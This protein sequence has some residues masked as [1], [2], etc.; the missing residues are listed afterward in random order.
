VSAI[1]GNPFTDPDRRAIWE[2]L[3]RRDIEG[4]L[5]RDWEL[6]AE[7]FLEEGF[8]GLDGRFSSDPDTWELTFPNLASYREAWLVQSRDFARTEF[9]DDPRARLYE[10]MKL[11]SIRLNGDAA[12]AHKKFDGS[13]LRKDGTR[14]ELHWQSLF[15]CRKE[16]GRWKIAGFVGYLPNPLAPATAS[17]R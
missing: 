1:P 8:V 6:G 10:A 17:T 14:L 5:A 16:Q 13:I 9:H 15:F 2:M 12:L 7:D 11:T 3:V 4:F